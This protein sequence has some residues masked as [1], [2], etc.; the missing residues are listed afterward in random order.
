MIALQAKDETLKRSGVFK[1]MPNTACS[2]QVGVGA[3]LKHFWRLNHFSVKEAN[4]HSAHLRLTQTVG[5]LVLTS[6]HRSGMGRKMAKVFIS[7]YDGQNH[8][9][10]NEFFG[11][12]K[13]HGFEAKHSP[14]SPHSGMKDE[15]WNNWYQEGLPRAI[16]RAEIFIAVI[17]PPCDGSTW[18]MIEYEEAYKNFLITGKPALY[19]IRLDSAA[20]PV[21][22]PEH[23]LSNSVCLSSIPEEAVKT[24]I[25]SIS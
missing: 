25:H 20:S 22:Y 15:R 21:K 3:F 13:E 1:S 5:C 16:Q 12:L 7:W 17:T 4:P 23:Y 9:L 24:L 11:L 6:N 14:H 2:R 18:M 19:F 10:A 8:A